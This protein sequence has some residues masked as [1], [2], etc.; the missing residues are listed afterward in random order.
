[1]IEEEQEIRKTNYVKIFSKQTKGKKGFKNTSFKNKHGNII[2]KKK[3][4]KKKLAK[5]TLV[6]QDNREEIFP[7]F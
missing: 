4:Q 1:M 3:V 5:K 6:R 7:C 2:L